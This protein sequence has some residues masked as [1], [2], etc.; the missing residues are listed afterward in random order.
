MKDGEEPRQQLIAE[1]SSQSKNG[2]ELDQL[3]CQSA[4]RAEP[5]LE[6]A[7][8]YRLLADNI[9]DVIWVSNLQSPSRISYVSPSVTGLLGYS[10]EEAIS[11]TMEEVF[12][13]QSVLAA[14]RA[15]AEELALASRRGAGAARSRVF[16]LELFHKNGS[17]VPVEV[18]FTYLPGPDGN[19]AE[20]L[21]VAR[22]IGERKRVEQEVRLSTDKLLKA[23]EDTMHALARVVEMRDPY[24]AG[25]QRR[26]T[27]LACAIATGIGMSS[28]RITGLR[29]AGLIHDIGKVRVPSEIL[30]NPDGL[31]EAE[32][33]IIKTHPTLGYDILK[34]IEFPWPVADIVY[35]HHERMDGSGYPQRLRGESIIQEA[36]V[37]AVADVV[38]AIA[39][40]RPYRPALGIDH[41]LQ[42]ISNNRGRLYERDAVDACLVLF[43]ERAFEF[44]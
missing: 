44:H 42:E 26:A 10:V 17:I 39:S 38:E 36:R 13:P 18:K 21:A 15:L 37:L 6:S 40:H 32:F 29:L 25:H 33:A 8:R 3:R 2:P 43:R 5:S 14:R 30:T 28:D 11:R 16:E 24:T 9:A 31:S 1:S 34:T 19:P 41:A 20:I 4:I 22:D 12:T 7:R 23:M 35:Q 27:E